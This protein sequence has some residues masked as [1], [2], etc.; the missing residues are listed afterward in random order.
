M[1]IKKP[2]RPTS[3]RNDVASHYVAGGG[4]LAQ[5]GSLSEKA[6][7]FARVLAFA[8][9][10][11]LA[12]PA[13]A[14][15]ELK[16]DPADSKY[17]QTL[18]GNYLATLVAHG[19]HDIAKAAEFF[20]HA[21]EKDPN[22]KFLLGRTFTLK[23]ANGDVAQALQLAD[24]VVKIDNDNLLGR[25]ALGVSAMKERSYAGARKNFNQVGDGPLAHLSDKLMSA[26][27]LAGAG[28]TN[29]AIKLLDELDGPNWFNTFRL[30]HA[31]LI[32]DFA[33]R[34]ETAASKFA[35]AY[36]ADD[37][38]VRIVEAQARALALAGEKAGALGVL[39][40]FDK[41]ASGNPILTRT[42]EMIEE[43]RTPPPMV[44]S[45]QAGAAEVLYGIGAALGQDGDE[46]S[47][48]AY[49][50]LSLY[51]DP[52]ATLALIPLSKLFQQIGD[53]ERAIAAL[54]RI[55]EG[56]PLH[57]GVQIDIALNYN[58]L[59]KIDEARAHLMKLIDADPS[60]LD[61]VVALGNV[62]RGHQLFAEA[63]KVYTRGID[64]LGDDPG[65]AY[66]S[67]FYFRGI[68]LERTDRW[69]EAEAD[70]ETTLKLYP[71]QPMVLNYLGY[72]WVD[73]GMHLDKALGMIE[74]AVK[75]RPSD[76][77]IVDSLG[78]AY[79]KL[80]RYDDAVKEL[81]RAVELHSEDPTINDH[82]GDAYWKVGR[83]LEATFQWNHARDL[84]P[85]PDLLVTIKR[86]LKLGLEKGTADVDAPKRAANG[87]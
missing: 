83:K 9:L 66:W 57:D 52:K 27:A 68:T 87:E 72:S 76:G 7:R 12:M 82:L 42:R 59:D 10:H 48:A 3:L 74:K 50:Q 36:K 80:D 44:T 19:N 81:E 49:L 6:L 65:R 47:P 29:D 73:K 22:S 56:S 14:S 51:L 64:A 32:L 75:L 77:Y 45:A 63:A 84:D 23:L 70:F 11:L 43:G 5:S 58:A 37:N 71:D 4:V 13:L 18:S 41:S 31:G 67:L 21:L 25:L 46:E 79:Y 26:W 34:R 33:N 2:I 15:A 62:L 69:P 86:K 61:A 35:A 8:G 78:W 1:L 20:S 55:P 16:A 28:R 30:Y 39:D 54:E 53:H 17:P 24:H 60:D 40:R 85:G 38:S